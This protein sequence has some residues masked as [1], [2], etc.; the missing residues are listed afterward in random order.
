[1]V[2]EQASGKN[3]IK[4]IPM[5]IRLQTEKSKAKASGGFFNT[6]NEITV[7]ACRGGILQRKPNKARKSRDDT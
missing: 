2:K 7:A 3:E 4:E 5:T 6:R 1:M